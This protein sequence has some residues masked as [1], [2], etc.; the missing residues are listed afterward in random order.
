MLNNVKRLMRPYNGYYKAYVAQN[1]YINERL[2]LV[3]PT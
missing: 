3:G 2:I 1:R